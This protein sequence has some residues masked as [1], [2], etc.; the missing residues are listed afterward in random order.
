[1][2]VPLLYFFGAATATTAGYV[3]LDC[4]RKYW[5]WYRG[6]D[7]KITEVAKK[8]FDKTPK[9]EEHQ[10]QKLNV[11]TIGDL[12][13]TILI[14]IFSFLNLQDFKEIASVSKQWNLVS[15]SDELWKVRLPENYQELPGESLKEK[16]KLL[17]KGYHP[18]LD[19]CPG[20][21]GKEKAVTKSD[22]G[23]LI[24]G[25]QDS[26]SS[27]SSFSDLKETYLVQLYPDFALKYHLIK[28]WRNWKTIP[29]EFSE[30]CRAPYEQCDKGWWVC[31]LTENPI[32]TIVRPRGY[33]GIDV[34][35]E[36]E[37]LYKYWENSNNFS[38]L[39]PGWPETIAFSDANFKEAG[40]VQAEIDDRLKK[41]EAQYEEEK[42]AKINTI[43]E[44]IE[45][46]NSNSLQ[47]T[48]Q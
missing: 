31:C 42:A 48:I 28:D 3:I 38:K 7:E 29:K 1:M 36:K 34:Q 30:E 14:N 47:N 10:S 24:K 20:E 44:F 32:R 9:G 6:R 25:K 18:I 33:Q 37:A 22:E 41:L 13:E 19:P 45:Y 8:K 35:Y 16:L 40:S 17:H 23:A 39:P 21:K 12:D 46:I 2:I 15:S 43:S 4:G 27:P 5:H 11:K 26:L